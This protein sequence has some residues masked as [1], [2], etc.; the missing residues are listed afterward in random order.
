MNKDTAV[1]EAQFRNKVRTPKEWNFAGVFHKTPQESVDETQAPIDENVQLAQSL[2]IILTEAPRKES[3]CSNAPSI[4]ELKERIGKFIAR[5]KDFLT[6]YAE[7]L[8][9]KK[10]WEASLLTSECKDIDD[11]VIFI[12]E[13]RNDFMSIA[14]EHNT[15]LANRVLNDWT[16]NTV[17]IK[18]FVDLLKAADDPDDI[19]YVDKP[20]LQSRLRSCR[21]EAIAVLE[22]LHAM[23]EQRARMQR[24]F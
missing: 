1:E 13:A 14:D 15:H 6:D 3:A 4:K 7:F 20:Q 5:N 12:M 16:K 8:A 19:A 9:Y 22:V 17:S 18:R 24:Q 21:A 10:N 2:Q 11:H 23:A